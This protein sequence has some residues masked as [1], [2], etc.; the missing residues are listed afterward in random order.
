MS[1]VCVRVL[2]G[3]AHR[4]ASHLLSAVDAP[5]LKE[6]LQRIYYSFGLER[7]A[8]PARHREPG[9]RRAQARQRAW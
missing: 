4:V 1:R 6:H 3:Q 5:L 9:V 2:G 8:Q 7:N